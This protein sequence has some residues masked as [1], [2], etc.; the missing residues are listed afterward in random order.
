MKDEEMKVLNR[1]KDLLWIFDGVD[2][3]AELSMFLW[4]YDKFNIRG[5]YQY[6]KTDTGYKVKKIEFGYPSGGAIEQRIY[7]FDIRKNG[8]ITKQLVSKSS[9]F[10]PDLV[11]PFPSRN[12]PKDMIKWLFKNRFWFDPRTAI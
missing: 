10:I 4:A 3:E 2:T 6:T 9:E 12:R 7:I 8:D 1:K 5:S 11:T